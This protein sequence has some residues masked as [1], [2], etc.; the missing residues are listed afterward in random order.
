MKRRLAAL[1]MGVALFL[2]A[3]WSAA[4]AGVIERTYLPLILDVQGVVMPTATATQTV[5]ATG[6]PSPASRSSS[7]AAAPAA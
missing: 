4:G 1:A 6:T 5:D 7:H 2:L 3:L